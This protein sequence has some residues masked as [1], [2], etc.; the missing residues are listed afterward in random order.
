MIRPE[1]HK[2]HRIDAPRHAS[3]AYDRHRTN[4]P[5]L[6]EAGIVRSSNRWKRLRLAFISSHPVCADPHK[7][8]GEFPPAA[9]EIHH[10]ESLQARPDLAFDPANLMALCRPC[11]AVFSQAERK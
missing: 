11:H 10:I 6:R 3:Q 5:G 7:R 4:A 2:P 8:H 9:A 1:K